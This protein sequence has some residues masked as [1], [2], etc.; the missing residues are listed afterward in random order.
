MV[1]T[2]EAGSTR[3]ASIMG[4]NSFLGRNGD[5]NTVML[6]LEEGDVVSVQLQNNGGVIGS[7]S[8]NIF[9]T[10]SGFLLFQ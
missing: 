8:S 6:E 9:S 4:S 10:F 5:A 2:T 1:H 7:Q 3:V